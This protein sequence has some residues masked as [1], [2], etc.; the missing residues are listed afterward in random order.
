M[1]MVQPEGV[2]TNNNQQLQ[3]IPVITGGSEDGHSIDDELQDNL[4]SDYYGNNVEV[5]SNPSK[6]SSRSAGTKGTTK[7]RQGGRSC[8]TQADA[9]RYHTTGVIEDIKVIRRIPY[10]VKLP[11]SIIY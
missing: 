7:A 6:G 10:G 1:A 4:N 5:V 11:H 9:R 8:G 2:Y 3:I